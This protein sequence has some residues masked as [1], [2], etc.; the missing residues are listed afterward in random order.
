MDIYDDF[1]KKEEIK[2]SNTKDDFHKALDDLT[3]SKINHKELEKII[4]ELDLFINKL[5]TE[6][7]MQ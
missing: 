5:P 6:G 1:N 4:K 3:I 2:P 7:G